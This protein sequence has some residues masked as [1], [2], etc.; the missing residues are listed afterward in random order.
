MDL[1][2]QTVSPT[3]CPPHKRANISRSEK[4]SAKPRADVSTSPHH[5]SPRSPKPLY[6]PPLITPPTNVPSHHTSHVLQPMRLT[7][8]APFLPRPN[9]IA[10]SHPMDPTLG[11][12]PL[13]H[14]PTT[15]PPNPGPFSYSFANFFGLP[16]PPVQV[17]NHTFF[18]N[19]PAWLHQASPYVKLPTPPYFQ[20][21]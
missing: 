10:P 16:P 19:P 9:P 11:P 7:P 4:N 5:V 6:F 1:D 12:H 18:R 13:Y 21:H 3:P 20:Q 17:T 15:L 2:C 14:N 8:T